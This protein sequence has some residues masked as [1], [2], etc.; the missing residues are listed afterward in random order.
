MHKLYGDFLGGRAAIGLLLLRIVAGAAMVIH[1]WPKIQNPTGWM[2]GMSPNT[3]GIVQAL[4]ALGEFAGGLG[5]IVGCLTPI[6]AFGIAATMSGAILIGGAGA[7]WISSKPSGRSFEM[8]SLYLL[9]AVAVMLIGP[10]IYSL[11]AKLF[12][13]RR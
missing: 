5:L 11:D 9:I 10:G 13:K 1:G 12:G 3:P 2:S 4:A 8:A 6:A 7:P